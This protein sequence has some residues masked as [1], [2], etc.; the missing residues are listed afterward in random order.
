[1]KFLI[2]LILLGIGLLMIIKTEGM[3]RATGEIGWAQRHLG[4]AG[5]YTLYKLVGLAII[6]I[7]MMYVTGLFQNLLGG[8]LGGLFG[9]IQAQ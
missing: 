3:V 9:G 4:G 7:G 5:T 2:F 8:L 6:L 1:M